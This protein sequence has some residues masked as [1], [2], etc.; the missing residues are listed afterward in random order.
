MTRAGTAR[1]SRIRTPTACWS[2][3]TTGT[4][5]WSKLRHQPGGD[6]ALVTTFA[7]DSTGNRPTHAAPNGVTTTA[8]FDALNR[9]KTIT[10]IGTAD[11]NG[12]EVP[13]D[14]IYDL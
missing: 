11:L 13:G 5:G 3:S 8:T 1:R 12:D 7:Y 14:V 2:R 4:A 10:A 9:V 6:P